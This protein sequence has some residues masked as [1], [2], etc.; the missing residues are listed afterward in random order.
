MEGLPFLLRLLAEVGLR[1]LLL[2]LWWWPA[3]AVGKASCCSC[4]GASWGSSCCGTSCWR[5]LAL[6]PEL[7]ARLASELRVELSPDSWRDP[8]TED[9]MTQNIWREPSKADRMARNKWCD[10]PRADRMT[11]VSRACS[12][13][14]EA[15][16]TTGR[17]PHRLPR[18]WTE[19]RRRAS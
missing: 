4:C 7:L 1:F 9:G 2:L 13:K 19:L 17:R 10:P 18:L 14:D 8:P 15:E 5:L 16:A 3:A 12:R 11:E 6:P